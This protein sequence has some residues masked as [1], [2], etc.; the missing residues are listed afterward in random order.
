MSHV[1]NPIQACSEVFVKPRA[2]FEALKTHNNWSWVPFFLTAIISALPGYLYF[3]SVDQA[4]YHSLMKNSP[5]MIDLSPAEIETALSFMQVSQIAV[6]VPIFSIIGLVLVN[7]IVAVYY[8]SVT[9]SDEENLA[10]FTDWY[11]AC[12]WIGLPSLIGALISVVFL[13]LGNA[14]GEISP[15]LA[16]ATSLGNIL[17]VGLD[18]AWFNFANSVRLEMIWSFYI[19]AVAIGTWTRFDFNKCLVLAGI[20]YVIIYGVWAFFLII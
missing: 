4:Y 7:A 13:L 6:M 15:T 18:S 20:P 17:G 2:V 11:G 9:S 16:S 8:K 10:G 12:W 3:S 19:A 14:N 5:D 1:T